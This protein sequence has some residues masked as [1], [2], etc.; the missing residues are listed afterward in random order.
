MEEF[1][2]VGDGAEVAPPPGKLG[3]APGFFAGPDAG[4]SLRMVAVVM[5]LVKLSMGT[6]NL[7]LSCHLTTLLEE[8]G[9]RRVKA[10][11]KMFR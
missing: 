1:S 5:I 3:I 11:S 10:G 4:L 2:G 7:K 9:L 8:Y 6:G